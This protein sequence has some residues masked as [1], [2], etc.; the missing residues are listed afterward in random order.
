MTSEAAAAGGSPAAPSAR[1]SEGN[2]ALAA[3][4]LNAPKPLEEREEK[5]KKVTAGSA[6]SKSAA[7]NST[8]KADRLSL[9]VSWTLSD[10][11]LRRS[12][13]AGQTWE[14]VH[15]DQDG[16]FRALSV[17][18]RELWVGGSKGVLYHSADE[19]THW[20]R[21]VPSAGKALLTEDVLQ[22]EFS[23]ADHGKLI[24][25]KSEWKTNNCGSTWRRALKK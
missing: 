6:F 16:Q 4:V 11:E 7:P 19:G 5:D 3:P 21:V 10:G 23:N 15:F 22:L 17:M 9:F 1:K 8:L 18:G 25:A 20:S 2:I 14:A 12:T 24:T 13:N